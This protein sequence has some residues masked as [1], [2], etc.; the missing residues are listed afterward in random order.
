MPF[1]FSR[2]LFNGFKNCFFPPFTTMS[3]FSRHISPCHPHR[4]IPGGNA[5]PAPIPSF[6]FVTLGFLSQP[7]SLLLLTAF[8]PG[9]L[10]PSLCLLQSLGPCHGA[11]AL[12]ARTHAPLFLLLL[13]V[14]FAMV[15]HFLRDPRLFPSPRLLATAPQCYMYKFPSHSV[16]SS[17]NFGLGGYA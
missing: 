6:L 13:A 4:C 11:H 12:C 15:K 2:V 14:R 7:A 1:F 5:L 9:T 3:M 17:N 8:R 16:P 10:V